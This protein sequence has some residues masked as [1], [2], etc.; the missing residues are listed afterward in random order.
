MN[1]GS[2]SDRT[3]ATGVLRM[4]L[5]SFPWCPLPEPSSSY[6]AMTRVSRR[7]SCALRLCDAGANSVT[8]SVRP[9][10]CRRHHHAAYSPC[11]CRGDR[12]GRRHDPLLLGY[13]G[14]HPRRGPAYRPGRELRGLGAHADAPAERHD[15]SAAGDQSG[16]PTGG[17]GEWRG[18]TYIV[19]TDGG[20]TW[21][22]GVVP[23][24]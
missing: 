24:A 1:K 19:T 6:L 2:M 21:R 5:L 20:A 7:R 18:G 11:C 15:E 9:H 22:A 23:G 16:Q 3:P 10:S 8:R 12:R 4:T 14:A 13:L 17:L